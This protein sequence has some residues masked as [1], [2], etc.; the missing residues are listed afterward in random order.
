MESQ[1]GKEDRHCEFL[2]KRLQKNQAKLFPFLFSQDGN[3]QE[4][5][6]LVTCS[7]PFKALAAGDVGLVAAHEG[8]SLGQMLLGAPLAA[9][10][11][12][13]ALAPSFSLPE[14]GA[15]PSARR[16]DRAGRRGR[17]VAHRQGGNS[18]KK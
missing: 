10:T 6:H 9:P 18:F 4:G 8:S 16:N 5:E 7:A 12:Q 14:A 2:P 1:D 17:S 13:T 15:E 11:P 3:E